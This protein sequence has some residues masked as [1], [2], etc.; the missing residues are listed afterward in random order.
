M[1]NC[2]NRYLDHDSSKL[3]TPELILSEIRNCDEKVVGPVLSIL[4]DKF[5]KQKKQDLEDLIRELETLKEMRECAEL[6]I[7]QRHYHNL[8]LEE[9]ELTTRV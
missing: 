9:L 1:Q 3:L 6:R 7:Q 4:A 8:Q 5:Q 2:H